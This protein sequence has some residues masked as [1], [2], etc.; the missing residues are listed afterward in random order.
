MRNGA[1]YD[2]KLSIFSN[3]DIDM[4]LGGKLAIKGL[5]N[6]YSQFG[7][8]ATGANIVYVLPGAYPASNGY[9]LSSTTGGT[10]SWVAQ[11][12]GGGAGETFNPFLLAG[13]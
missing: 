10:M 11:S 8:P 1:A 12:G 5:T 13:M 9:V 3:G 7:A 2:T 6:G 4:E